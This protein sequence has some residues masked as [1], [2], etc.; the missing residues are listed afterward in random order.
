MIVSLISDV[1]DSRH[2]VGTKLSS[3]LKFQL[4]LVNFKF[5]SALHH[6]VDLSLGRFLHFLKHFFL[7]FDSELDVEDYS[8]LILSFTELPVFNYNVFT[9]GRPPCLIVKLFLLP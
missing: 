6:L 7:L 5:T 2:Q 1:E 8:A 9:L 3:F 4:L